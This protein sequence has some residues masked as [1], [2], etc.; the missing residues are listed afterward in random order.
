MDNELV[1]SSFG[2]SVQLKFFWR[3]PNTFEEAKTSQRGEVC[4]YS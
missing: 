2:I 3:A 1:F 4:L